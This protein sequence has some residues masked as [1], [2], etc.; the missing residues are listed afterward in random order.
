MPIRI[1]T[2]ERGG[3]F[4]T[5]GLALKAVLERIQTLAPV[6]VRGSIHASIGN[7][8]DLHSGDIDFG[9]MAANWIGRARKGERPFAQS[10][11]LRMVAP[12]NAG[13][14]FFIARANSPIRTIADLRGKSIVVGP[15][16]G[17]MA[18]HAH[19]ILGVLG[20]SFADFTP[21][22]LDFASGADALAAGEVDAQF[23]CPIPNRVM[24]DLSKRIDVRVLSYGPGQLDKVLKAVPYYRPT[25][26]RKGAIRGLDAGAPQI[27]VVNVL[28]THARTVES[29]VCAAVRAI[30]SDA[31]ELGQLNPLFVGLVDL[32]LPLRSEGPA[33]LEFGGVP[34]HPGALRAYREIGL[35]G[36][37]SVV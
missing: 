12:M 19:T 36:P 13:P 23:Q 26:I 16:K 4:Y 10:I 34:F 2:A 15:A 28:V 30:V 9:F 24:T 11:E 18:Q 33:A 20:L 8:N 32:F 3:T 21:V 37:M 27:A 14:L 31:E 22:Y 7:A 35:L 25:V 17:G 1:G 6:E 29:T 5:Q